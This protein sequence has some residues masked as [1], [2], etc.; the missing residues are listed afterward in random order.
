MPNE[1]RLRRDSN[2]NMKYTTKNNKKSKNYN[3]K[4]LL[5]MKSSR[6][7]TEKY[8]PLENTSNTYKKSAQLIVTNIH[9]CLTSLVDIK[10]LKSSIKSFL[11][12]GIQC[13]RLNRS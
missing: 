10:R 4:F 11:N 5:P 6:S 3:N 13:N 1:R 12:K 8:P 2:R 9:R 7:S